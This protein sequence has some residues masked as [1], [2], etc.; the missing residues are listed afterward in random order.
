MRVLDFLINHTYG[1]PR[2]QSEPVN[3][4]NADKVEFVPIPPAV[5]PNCG[6]HHNLNDPDV[7]PEDLKEFLDEDTG[8]DQ[9]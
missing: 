1:R 9:N 2:I 4:F 8:E 3:N 5:C 6:Y 7:I